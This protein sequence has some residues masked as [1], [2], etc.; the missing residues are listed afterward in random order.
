MSFV[1][2][3]AP[4]GSFVVCCL[5]ALR[6][7]L[8]LNLRLAASAR[9]TAQWALGIFLSLSLNAGAANLTFY[10]YECFAY[11]SVCHIYA[12]CLWKPRVTDGH[13]LSV[14]AGNLCQ[15]G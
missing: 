11:I 14:G 4:V 1:G 12:W 7:D 10:V 3:H 2:E 8:S 13:E 6:Q 15:S 5:T 9:L